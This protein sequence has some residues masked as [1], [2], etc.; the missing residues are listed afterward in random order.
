MDIDLSKFSVTLPSDN[1]VQLIQAL[2][3]YSKIDSELKELKRNVDGLRK[4]YIDC[5]EALK[6]KK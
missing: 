5:L 6:S 2:D 3:N 4:L 1:F